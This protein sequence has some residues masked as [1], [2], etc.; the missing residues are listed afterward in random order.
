MA[1]STLT[2]ATIAGALLLSANGAAAEFAPIATDFEVAA[3]VGVVLPSICIGTFTVPK[4]MYTFEPAGVNETLTI[5]TNPPDLVES[6]F[7]EDTGLIFFKFNQT[8]VPT[9]ED[10]GIIIKFPPDQLES[11]NVCCTQVAQIKPGFTNFKSL[12]VTTT[13]VVDAEFGAQAGDLA[14]IVQSDAVVNVKVNATDESKVGIAVQEDATINV[15]GDISV[16]NCFDGSTCNVNG[17]VAFPKES[18][19]RDATITTPSCEEIKLKD[20]ATCESAEPSVTVTTDGPVVFSGVKE[21][22]YGGE[23]LYGARGPAPTEPPTSSPAPTMTSS[24][25]EAPS[26]SPDDAGVMSR[27]V[28]VSAV[29]SGAA[30]LFLLCQ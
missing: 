7:D 21:D 14:V 2:A 5:E 6:G 30:F 25:T 26:E 29:A 17:A 18:V 9:A 4:P 27:G 22:C 10:A 12:T 11:I 19:A 24:P 16:L 1:R 23:D 3:A 28:F 20:D 15:D 13:S 8:V